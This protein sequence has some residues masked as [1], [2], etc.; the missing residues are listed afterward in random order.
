LRRKEITSSQASDVIRH[1]RSQMPSFG[2]RITDG[3]ISD[4]IAYL[5][6]H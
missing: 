6:A 4:L 2:A 1:G 5:E 3:Q